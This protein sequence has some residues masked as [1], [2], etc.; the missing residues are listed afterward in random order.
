MVG[1]KGSK[2]QANGKKVVELS[3][4]NTV[5]KAPTREAAKDV[6]RRMHGVAS[7]HEWSFSRNG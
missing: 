4:G 2:Y 5:H 7:K 1:A 6:A 3:T